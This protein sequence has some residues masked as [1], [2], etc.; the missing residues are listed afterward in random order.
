MNLPPIAE[1]LH[2]LVAAERA[3]GLRTVALVSSHRAVCVP[4]DRQWL[5]NT[6]HLT[7]FAANRPGDYYRI[8]QHSVMYSYEHRFC[9]NGLQALSANGTRIAG[10]GDY[11]RDNLVGKTILGEAFVN[12]FRAVLN[13]VGLQKAFANGLPTLFQGFDPDRISQVQGPP[14]MDRSRENARRRIGAEIYNRACVALMEETGDIPSHA[15]ILSLL[16][17]LGE[18]AVNAVDPCSEST[19]DSLR[20]AQQQALPL[21]P[22]SNRAIENWRTRRVQTPKLTSIL[23]AFDAVITK[24][25]CSVDWNAPSP[26]ASM[27][28]RLAPPVHSTSDFRL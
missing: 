16:Q 8:R 28:Q 6:T 2:E 19:A 27:V 21:L 14:T 11:Y 17:R 15:Q 10:F 24:A 20:S 5:V 9:V 18:D 1:S 26:A 4:S 7:G 23:E 22:L 25:V 3:T 12:E 13:R